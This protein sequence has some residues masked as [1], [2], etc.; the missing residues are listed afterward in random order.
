MNVTKR[1]YLLFLE[2]RDSWRADIVTANDPEEAIKA[3]MMTGLK[4]KMFSQMNAIDKAELRKQ[5][6]AKRVHDPLPLG[7]AK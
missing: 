1:E 6:A 5:Y 4:R 2:A 7:C 3:Q